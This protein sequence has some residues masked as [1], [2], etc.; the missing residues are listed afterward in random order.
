MDWSGVI[1]GGWGFEAGSKY[2]AWSRKELKSGVEEVERRRG[3]N[4]C[5][6]N[7]G[8]PGQLA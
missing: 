6:E 1:G 3:L 7:R 5:I 8:E 2:D 4:G